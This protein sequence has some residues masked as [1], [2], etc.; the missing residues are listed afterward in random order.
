MQPL[1]VIGDSSSAAANTIRLPTSTGGLLPYSGLPGDNECRPHDTL[2]R[3]T[4]HEVHFSRPAA[5]E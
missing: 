3:K 5:N 4:P 2:G 1:V